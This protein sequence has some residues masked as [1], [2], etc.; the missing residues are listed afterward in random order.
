[1][2]KKI[3]GKT[4]SLKKTTIEY[5]ESFIGNVYSP[6]SFLPEEVLAMMCEI[7]GDNQEEVAVCLDRHNRVLAVSYG[8][9]RSVSVPELKIRRS[10]GRLCAVRFIHTH[11]LKSE[12][13]SGILPSD[14]DINT[15]KKERYDAMAVVGV[16]DKRI[17]GASVTLLQQ[18]SSGQLTETEII[19]PCIYSKISRFDAIF[20][21][22]RSIDK[23]SNAKISEV[24]ADGERAILVGVIPEK[25][26]IKDSEALLELAELASSAGAIVVAS[27]T[28]R[29][30]APNAGTYIGS[31]F[32]KDLALKRQALNANLVI[33][34]DELTPTQIRNLESII[35]IKV[36]DR[37]ALI[38]DIFASR[39]KSTEGKYQVE[40]AQQK[41]RL[42]RLTGLGTVLS[43]LGGGI[44][45][46]GP[47]ETKLEEDKRHIRRKIYY[48]E[49]KL[50]EI[51]VRR[52]L[53]R[54]ER[55]KNNIPTVAIV[56][57]TNAGK[58]TL[59]NYMCETN[60][61]A[62]DKLF[63]TLD[64]SVRRMTGSEK[65]DILMIDTVGFVKKL[66]T[67][68]VEAFKA[69]LEE[70]VYADLILHVIDVSSKDYQVCLETVEGILEKI[71]ATTS[72]RY[73]LFNKIDKGYYRDIIP[74]SKNFPGYEKVF[75][76]SSITGEGIEELREAINGFFTE[77]I[78][79][80]DYVISY[81]NMKTI[82]FLHEKCEHLEEEYTDKGVRVRGAISEKHAYVLQ[83]LQHN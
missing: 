72:P 19:G 39:A 62:E 23:I 81:N 33:F 35:G 74:C 43:R 64:T 3:Y 40:L 45:T 66:P 63:A 12:N 30:K 1:M 82:N 44:G 5:M 54:S 18:N 60:V 41:Y 10:E 80:F 50:K 79:E 37:T 34:D 67:D 7:T 27:Y 20:D 32:A 77:N 42:P 17:I 15:L 24:D 26:T 73:L 36:I 9:F 28:Q 31:G 68:L 52:S 57:Y 38:L 21:E 11:P 65:K 14:V 70:S 47:G 13:M 58:S 51:T 55:Q 71:G 78:I 56:G 22:I 49:E 48:L 6:G 2:E 59:M 83:D 16:Y 46:R 69:T 29:R 8:D 61:I 53:M 4:D 76:V 25:D 75:F